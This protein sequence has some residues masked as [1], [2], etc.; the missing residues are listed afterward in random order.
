MLP[1]KVTQKPRFRS[2]GKG[3]M[4]VIKSYVQRERRASGHWML[5]QGAIVLHLMILARNEV[6]IGRM[7]KKMLAVF[8]MFPILNFE[9][10]EIS[11][12]IFSFVIS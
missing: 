12:Y 7:R 4:Q 5:A 8:L 10:S 2:K 1:G 9:Y 6:V 11:V 3:I